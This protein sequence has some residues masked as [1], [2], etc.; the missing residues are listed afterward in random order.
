ML[1]EVIPKLPQDKQQDWHDAATTFRLPYWDWA[2]KK[3]RGGLDIYDIPMIAKDPRIEVVNLEDA[4]TTVFINNPMYKFKMPD[5]ERMGCSGVSD[6]QDTTSDGQK[7]V[8]I[9]VSRS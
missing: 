3:E 6:V 9:P 1:N 2:E 4:T 8:T 5:N 7:I